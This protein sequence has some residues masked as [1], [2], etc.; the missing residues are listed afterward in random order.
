LGQESRRVP[1][2]RGLRRDQRNPHPT[3]GSRRATR[4]EPEPEA[5]QIKL[6]SE[7]DRVN[8]EPEDDDVKLEPEN[9]GVRIKKEEFDEE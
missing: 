8:F 6:E 1:R 5:G 2:P 7:N 4:V 9:E 3:M